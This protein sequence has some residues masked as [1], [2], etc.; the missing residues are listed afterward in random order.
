MPRVKDSYNRI[1]LILILLLAFYLRIDTLNFRPLWLDEAMEYWVATAPLDQLSAVVKDA[2]QD[3]PLYSLI[4][5]QWLHLGRDEFT[6][7]AL[8][9]FVSVL[10]VAAA[11]AFGRETYGR[12]AGLIAALL[13]ALL[14]PHIRM[15]QEVGQYAFLVFLLLLNL[16]VL[17]YARRTNEK[18]QWAAWTVSAL[19]AVYN[20]YGALLIILPAA[21][22]VFLENIYRRRTTGLLNQALAS[23]LFIL[24]ASPLLLFWLPDQLF[25]GPVSSAFQVQIG[26]LTD[27]VVL[28]LDRTR[29][30]LAYQFTGLIIDPEAWAILRLAAWLLLLLSLFFAVYGLRKSSKYAYLLFWLLAA[31]AA[32]YVLGRLGAYPYGGTRHALILAPL[33]IPVVAIGLSVMWETW[34]PLSAVALA[35]ILV[36]TALAPVEG[37][38][39]TRSVV[40]QFLSAREGDTPAYVYYNGV[41]AVRYQIGLQQGKVEDIPAA[42]FRTCWAGED[43]PY[44]ARD[45][46]VYGRWMRQFTMD[47]KVNEIFRALGPAAQEAFWLIF[48][49]T[50]DQERDELFAALNPQYAIEQTFAAPAASAFL[51]QRK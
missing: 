12:R 32:Y 40:A 50:S 8:T 25:R 30:L 28:F 10:S 46:I 43:H 22:V 7:R 26:T 35:G 29:N 19:A 18:K 31:W 27:E 42:W 49:H 33:L 23:I 34:P 51:L 14:P 2:L 41:P 24:I 39:D 15:A 48:S 4:L 1:L 17:A 47:E 21:G 38:E 37:P 20:Y 13:F 9:T 3:P 44:C 5:S 45:H 36:V 16:L 11:Y 6:L